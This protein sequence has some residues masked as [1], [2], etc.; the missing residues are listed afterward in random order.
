MRNF[1]NTASGNWT[2]SQARLA[3]EVLAEV[4]LQLTSWMRLHEIIPIVP[5]NVQSFQPT[6]GVIGRQVI[7]ST[8]PIFTD[9]VPPPDYSSCVPASTPG[10]NR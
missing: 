4:P 10:R 2:I 6:T 7:S 9:D 1:V 3:K 5:I 8:A